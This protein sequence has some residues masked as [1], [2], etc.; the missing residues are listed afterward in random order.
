MSSKRLITKNEIEDILSFIK[1]QGSIPIEAAKSIVNE[2]KKQLREQLKSLKIYPEVIP[3]LK[4]MIEQ[5]YMEA[6]IQAGESVGVIG[7]QSIGEKQTQTTLNTFHKAGSGEKTITTGVPRIEELLNATKDPKS[8]NCIAFMKDKHKSISDIRQT[9]GHNIVEISFKKISKSY[10]II[11]DKSPEKWYESF[12]I[13]YGDEF[14]KF[15]DCISI[16]I[17]MD[18][19]YEYKLDLEIITKII[20]EK[21]SDM[22]C[23]FSPDNIGQI[24]IFVDTSD[25]NLPDNRVLFINSENVKEIYLEEVVQPTLYN[26]II[27]GIPGIKNI[28]FNDD[29]NSFET[30]GSNFQEL[31]GLPFIDSTKTISNNVW[32]IYNTLGVEATR[33]FLIEEFMSIMEGINRCHIQLL[34]EK[35]TFNGSISSISRY[36]MRNEECGPMGKASFEETMDN[37]LKAGLYGEQEETKGVSASIICGKIAH[38]GSGVCELIMDIKALPNHIPVLSQIVEEKSE[39]EAYNINAKYSEKKKSVE[40]EEPVEVKKKKKSVEKQQMLYLD[41]E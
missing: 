29:E 4:L 10:K 27:C 1:P 25:I 33:Q 30:D 34:S 9:I 16:K 22:I 35:M 31:L 26:I 23:V 24:D 8:V 2:N 15:S 38:I 28:Y 5:Q 36:T 12:K 21:Y 37:F 32:D 3:S 20:S 41:L 13:L 39:Q 7:A 40:N 14:T 17:D 11:V 18:I 19:L 6:K